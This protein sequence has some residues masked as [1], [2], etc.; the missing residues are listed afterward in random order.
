M[1][2]F[3]ASVAA[4]VVIAIVTAVVLEAM[5]LSSATTFSTTNVRL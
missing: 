3:I 1:K 2:S 4:L 5:D